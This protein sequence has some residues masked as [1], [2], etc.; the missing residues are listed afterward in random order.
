VVGETYVQ[1]GSSEVRPAVQ[2]IVASRPDIV[3]NTINGSSN[4][5]FFQELR[6]AGIRAADVP[7]LS[8]SIGEEQ[9]RRLDL[10]HM[11]GDYSAWTYFQSIDTPENRKFVHDFR[12]RFG[13]QRVVTDPM[14]AA[15]VGVELW[16]KAVAQAGSLVPRDIRNAMRNQRMRAPEGDVRIDAESQH[17]WKTPR[18]GRIRD[19]GQFDVIWTASAPEAPEPYPPSR[20][21]EDWRAFL[22]DLHRGWGGQ[23][24]APDPPH[25]PS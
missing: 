18:I 2:Q 8:F 9:L 25:P 7:T 13:Q 5:A 16:A 22:H 6:R 3:L 10:D 14:E 20:T 4:V 17:T 23:W 19:D 24:T 1:F 21:A 12:Q 15:Y 11:V